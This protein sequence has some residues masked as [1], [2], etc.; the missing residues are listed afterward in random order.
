MAAIRHG[1]LAGKLEKFAHHAAGTQRIVEKNHRACFTVAPF[2]GHYES[3]LECGEAVHAGD[4]VGLLHDFDR[5]ELEPWPCRA[6]VDG[7]VTAQAW[8]ARV[9][10]GQHIVVVAQPR[11]WRTDRTRD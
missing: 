5:P 11:A 9:A 3:L 6:G 2:A 4:A 10:Q 8:G 1:Q 7:F